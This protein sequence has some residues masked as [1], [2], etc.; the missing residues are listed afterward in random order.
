MKLYVRRDGHTLAGFRLDPPPAPGAYLVLE[1]EPI[2]ECADDGTWSPIF[3][4]LLGA[5]ERA[6]EIAIVGAA[7]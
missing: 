3:G 4:P 5:E 6:C 1:G 7:E 2:A